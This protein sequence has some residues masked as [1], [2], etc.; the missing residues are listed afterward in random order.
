MT[1][2]LVTRCLAAP[3][4]WEEKVRGR[5]PDLVECKLIT[6]CTWMDF[7]KEEAR[8]AQMN[9]I[10]P[11]GSVERTTEGGSHCVS[12]RE[13]EVPEVVTG[14]PLVACC[15]QGGTSHRMTRGRARLEAGC[16]QPMPHRGC[17]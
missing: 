17:L 2:S 15:S 13:K 3:P 6:K 12:F 4:S 7:R 9:H 1:N 11:Q 10:S 8:I 5:D 16:S 14:Q